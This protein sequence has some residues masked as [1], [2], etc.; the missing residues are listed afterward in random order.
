MCLGLLSFLHSPFF[1]T[2]FPVAEGTTFID[3]EGDSQNN[4][5][6]E[7]ND[8]QRVVLVP[9]EVV[10]GGAQMWRPLVP[11]HE[12]HPEH[13]EVQRLDGAVLVKAGETHDVFLI[14]KHKDSYVNAWD[15]DGRE[16]SSFYACLLASIVPVR[17]AT[18]FPQTW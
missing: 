17:N 16:L 10:G 11:H 3:N 6:E 9:G 4:G 8:V 2:A 7:A 14:A 5:Q 1:P 13:S 18:K 15:T 12:F